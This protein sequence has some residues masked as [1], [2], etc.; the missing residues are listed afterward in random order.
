MFTFPL[1]DIVVMWTMVVRIE[2]VLITFLCRTSIKWWNLSQI[3]CGLERVWLA[4]VAFCCCCWCIILFSCSDHLQI[5]FKYDTH[6]HFERTCLRGN[7]WYYNKWKYYHIFILLRHFDTEFL[8]WVINIA[9]K[10]FCVFSATH[11]AAIGYELLEN[12]K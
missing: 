7:N 12:I 11:I 3:H 4:H 8:K 9:F 1:H 10:K 2:P 6:H 5:C